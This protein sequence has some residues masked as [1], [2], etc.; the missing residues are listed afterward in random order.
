MSG[1][2]RNLT[3]QVPEAVTTA[4]PTKTMIF[5]ADH[6]DIIIAG[7]TYELLRVEYENSGNIIDIFNNEIMKNTWGRGPLLSDASSHETDA[8]LMV[9]KGLGITM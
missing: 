3:W 6:L 4:F 8:D 5:L 9:I 7:G 1:E 2:Y